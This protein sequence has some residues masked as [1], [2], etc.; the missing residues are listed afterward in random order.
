MSL[1]ETDSYPRA[2]PLLLKP[3][4][5]PH[6]VLDAGAA[7]ERIE[8]LKPTSVGIGGT[9]SPSTTELIANLSQT[10]QIHDHDVSPFT[11]IFLT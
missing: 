7:G 8:P 6:G 9:P 4:T 1:T 5:L 10:N 2:E 3:T 11:T